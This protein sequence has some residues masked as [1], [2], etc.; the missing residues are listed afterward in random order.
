VCKLAKG[1]RAV[2][3]ERQRVLVVDHDERGAL[4]VEPFDDDAGDDDAH[5]AKTSI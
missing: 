4:R 3:R 5:A 1:A 2:P